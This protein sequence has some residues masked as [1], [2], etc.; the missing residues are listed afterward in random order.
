MGINSFGRQS[1]LANL[2]VLLNTDVDATLTYLFP[3]LF[4]AVF[5]KHDNERVK[6]Q[7]AGFSQSPIIFGG[8]IGIKQRHDLTSFRP[9]TLHPPLPPT[10]D[11][12]YSKPLRGFCP[13]LF[14]FFKVVTL[15]H[16]SV[17]PLTTTRLYKENQ[18]G[19]ER[20]VYLHPMCME[21]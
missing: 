16:P 18:L 9:V 20:F 13:C 7:K 5:S 3:C 19:G 21:Q 12:I 17:L 8:E 14:C 15:L 2:D 6:T 4:S 1:T 10:P 11:T